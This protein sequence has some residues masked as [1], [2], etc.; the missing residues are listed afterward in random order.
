M[1][2]DTTVTITN[3]TP[4]KASIHAELVAFLKAGGSLAAAWKRAEKAGLTTQERLAIETEAR[5]RIYS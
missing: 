4:S 3:G 5:R 2:N 1:S